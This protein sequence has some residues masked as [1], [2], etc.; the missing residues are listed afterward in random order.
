M[1]VFG[2]WEPFQKTAFSSRREV[3]ELIVGASCLRIWLE[4]MYPRVNRAWSFSMTMERD[5]VLFMIEC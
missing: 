3:N 1:N 5:C 2:I 4:K